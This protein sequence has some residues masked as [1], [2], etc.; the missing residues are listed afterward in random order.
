MLPLHPSLNV[1]CPK[2]PYTLDT[3]LGNLA[4]VRC[5]HSS[6]H[7]PLFSVKVLF[8]WRLFLLFL[9]T[10]PNSGQT[11]FSLSPSSFLISHLQI[12]FHCFQH[13]SCF[14]SLFP[15]VCLYLAL[16]TLNYW[17]LPCFLFTFLEG[18]LFVAQIHIHLVTSSTMPWMSESDQ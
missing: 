13:A 14:V 6:R 15:L 8:W 3:C 17:W 10:P 7:A 18:S 5:W 9:P 11:F 2:Q 4:E 1:F 12:T 16:P